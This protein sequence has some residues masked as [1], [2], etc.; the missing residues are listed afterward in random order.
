[1]QSL[2]KLAAVGALVA[3][4][5]WSQMASAE[6]VDLQLPGV[7]AGSVTLVGPSHVQVN[8]TVDPNGLATSFFVQYGANNVLNLRTPSVSAGVGLD[9]LN[10]VADLLGL[11]PGTSYKYQIVAESP[12]GTTSG[13]VLSFFTP[14]SS[15]AP[16]S[17]NLATGSPTVGAQGVKKSARCTIVGTARSDVLKGTSKRDVICGLGGND[18]IRGLGGNDLIIGGKGRDRIVGGKGKDRLLGNAG[19]DR[20]NARDGKRGDRVNG[21]KGRDK[22]TV[23]RGDRVVASE[24]I[25]RR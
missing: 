22:V 7:T 16:V 14:G 4:I 9:P 24:S 3:S 21:G 6:T 8:A 2:Y 10:V 18:R 11:D 19:A 1:V 12:A 20:I 23:D 15:G 25:S 13:P 5:G 17:V